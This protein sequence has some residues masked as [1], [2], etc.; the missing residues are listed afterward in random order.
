MA[1]QKTKKQ[2]YVPQSY[3]RRFTRD[4]KNLYVFDKTSKKSFGPTSVI[5]V[6]H[7]N[8]F[9]DPPADGDS[10]AAGASVN[11]QPT[12]KA[13]AT[14]EGRFNRVIDVIIK[15]AEGGTATTEQRLEIAFCAAVQLVRTRDFRDDLVEAME[16]MGRATL[17][18]ALKLAAPELA[19]KV[20]AEFKYNK[21]AATALHG[22]F[23]WDFKFVRRVAETLCNHIWVVGINQTSV[24]LYTSDSPVVRKAHKVPASF[25][26]RPDRGPAFERAIDIVVESNLPGIANEGVEIAFP[27]SPE[28]VLSS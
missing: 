3:L 17:D 25:V 7:E 16:R 11:P 9:Y 4:G 20:K 5:N 10:D 8:Y 21:N 19:L 24:P 23:M 12:E 14:L 2:H 27:L 15:V 1:V 28:C 6:A 26:P 18:S 13:L 22:Q